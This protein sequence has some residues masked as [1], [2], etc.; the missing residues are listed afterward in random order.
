MYIY[1]STY[2]IVWFKSY[3]YLRNLYISKKKDQL[4]HRFVLDTLLCFT[5]IKA[6]FLADC[7][8]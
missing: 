1:I 3:V 2:N 5:V 4:D 8:E 7:N 6:H